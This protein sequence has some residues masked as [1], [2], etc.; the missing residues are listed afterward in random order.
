MGDEER[1]LE[2]EVAGEGQGDAVQRPGI[3][4]GVLINVL[5]WI[6]I[7]LAAVIVI[8]TVSWLTFSLFLHGREAQGVDIFSSERS[9][10]GAVDLEY[11]RAN[12]D[13]IRGQ[14]SDNPPL[15]FLAKVSIGYKKGDQKAQA[16]LVSKSDEIQN[17]ILI[18]L[19]KRKASELTTANLNTLQDNLKSLLQ[20]E[21]LTGN[22]VIY[23]V[24]FRELQT[25]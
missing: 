13:D 25:F 23:K 24:L 1:F 6:A 7:G 11:Y 5:K 9:R 15:T 20:T 4:S 16:E 22:I 14:T 2:E 21:V 3:L 8:A 19:G 17:T 10:A 12:L 18:Y